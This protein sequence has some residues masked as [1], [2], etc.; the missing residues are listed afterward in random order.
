MR[1]NHPKPCTRL[2]AAWPSPAHPSKRLGAAGLLSRVALA[3]V[4]HLFSTTVQHYH[5]NFVDP[6]AC[7]DC[8]C[9]WARRRTSHPARRAVGRRCSSASTRPYA[10]SWPRRQPATQATPFDSVVCTLEALQSAAVAGPGGDDADA[11]QAAPSCS[12]VSNQPYRP[13]TPPAEALLTAASQSS[14]LRL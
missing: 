11:P 8:C 6:H 13:S 1:H 10:S 12:P 5:V 3:H 7:C 9:S 2:P 14:R 4:E